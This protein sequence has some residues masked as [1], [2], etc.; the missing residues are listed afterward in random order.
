MKKKIQGSYFGKTHKLK[1]KPRIN[2]NKKKECI[3]N[4][5]RRQLLVRT[6]WY[7]GLT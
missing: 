3:A 4:F 2:N 1:S 7:Y 5:L 6:H